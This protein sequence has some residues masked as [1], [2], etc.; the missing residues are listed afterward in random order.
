VT[1]LAVRSLGCTQIAVGA[2][3]L[4]AP[5]FVAA[6]SRGPLPPT[7]IVRVLGAREVGQ[8]VLTATRADRRTLGLGAAV[9]ISHLASMVA[10]AI[11]SVRWRRTASSSAAI[12]A[13]SA[14]AGLAL[15]RGST[16]DA[17]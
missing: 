12:A 7:L 5:R 17:R 10:L 6:L 11:A 16:R 1:A 13:A 3:M 8:G 4:V 14:A 9:D 15:A 2:A